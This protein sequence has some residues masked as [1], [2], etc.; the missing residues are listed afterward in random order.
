MILNLKSFC[1]SDEISSQSILV[2]FSL[3]QVH[4]TYLSGANWY[5]TF[6]VACH[7][8]LT[9]NSLSPTKLMNCSYIS[10]FE[11]YTI[12][13]SALTWRNQQAKVGERTHWELRRSGSRSHPKFAEP[14]ML[15]E[16]WLNR[17]QWGMVAKHSINPTNFYYAAT[18][19]TAQVKGLPEKVDGKNRLEA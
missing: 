12:E 8:W 4:S 2:L 1:H 9:S 10:R 18:L 11:I 14:P 13:I 5:S 3:F 7:L 17:F 6:G 19:T 16:F 15:W